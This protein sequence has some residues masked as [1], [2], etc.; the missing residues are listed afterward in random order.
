MVPQNHNLAFTCAC[1]KLGIATHP[2]SEEDEVT[3][4]AAQKDDTKQA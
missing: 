1:S 4:L 2:S 3:D